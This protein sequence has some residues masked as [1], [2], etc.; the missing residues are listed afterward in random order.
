MREGTYLVEIRE[1][2]IDLR[3]RID[4]GDEHTELADAYLRHGFHRAVVSLAQ[5][6]VVR[7]TLDSVDQRSWRGAAAVR[8]LRWPQPA[9]DA[10]PDQRLLGLLALG[11]ANALLAQ[12]DIDSW[13]AAISPLRQAAAH[14]A[15]AND[16]QSLAESEY[17]RS[18]VELNL[19]HEYADGRR[20]AES[21]QVHFVA[22][23]DAVGEARASVL[24]ALNEFNLASR[25]GPNV[26]RADQ[27]ALLDTAVLRVL[28]ALRFF[29]AHEM[30]TDAIAALFAS[31]F[32][33]QR[34][35][36]IRARRARLSR[37]AGARAGTRRQTLRGAFSAECSR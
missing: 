16:M 17:Q 27:R 26:P 30:H 23:D 2:D 24:R 32:R 1:R 12:S 33:E 18:A 19:L 29:E 31:C 35:R 9:P 34:A 36:R 4:T 22:A 15:A 28:R 5:P 7:V 3:I 11:K 10:P 37:R 20:T 14:F 25:M 13:R 6:A 21:A 8:I